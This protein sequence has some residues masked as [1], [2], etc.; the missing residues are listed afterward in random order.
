MVL[1]V[2]SNWGDEKVVGL[3]EVEVFD[4]EGSKVSNF[5]VIMAA[6]ERACCVIQTTH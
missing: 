6:K 2:L 4:M 1:E 5:L 3:T